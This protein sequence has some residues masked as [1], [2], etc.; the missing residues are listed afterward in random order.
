MPSP[1]IWCG[2]APALLVS[3]WGLFWSPL[4]EGGN[5]PYPCDPQNKEK[6]ATALQEGQPAPFSGQ[7][8]TTKLAIELGQ[9]AEQFEIQLE[10]EKE[11]ERALSRVDLDLE[12][13]LRQLETTSWK[14]QESRYL[15]EIEKAYKWYRDPAFLILTS[16]ITFSL[17]TLAI[18]S[19]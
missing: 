12:H 16:G 13:K 2:W 3:L 6:C 4:A 19:R 5:P 18:I 17:L 10:W 14:Q 7:L 8:L 15:Q 1:V 9:K 11:R